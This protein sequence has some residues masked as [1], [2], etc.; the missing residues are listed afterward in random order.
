MTR[1][2]STDALTG[3]AN[4]RG[5]EEAM[6]REL[7]RARRSGAM[8]SLVLFDVD[9]FKRVNDT[10]GHATGDLVLQQVAS[11]LTASVRLTDVVSRWGGEEFLLLLSG[12]SLEG[13]RT[14][15]ERIRKRI[16]DAR[17]ASLP[18][19]TVSAGVAQLLPADVTGADVLGRADEQLY[20][21]KRSGR[22]RVS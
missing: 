3:L 6:R 13:A 16:E 1:M 5:G 8:L 19:V 10:Y 2:A 17:S 21:A 15:G 11:I 12:T 18:S 22:N 4:R 20:E 7:A 14:L 9:H